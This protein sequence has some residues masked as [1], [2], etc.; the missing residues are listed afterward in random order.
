[1]SEGN[2]SRFSLFAPADF[3]YYVKELE[4]FLSEESYVKYKCEVEVALAK[5]LAK[6]G[7]I[8]EDSAKE[9]ALASKR[10]TAEE[11][12]NEEQRTQHDIIALINMIRTKISDEAKSAV[13][14]TATSYDIV[15]TAN[16]KRYRDAF[17]KIIIP[18]LV[19]LEKVLIDIA[20]REKE[21]V[22]I[23][24]THLQHAEPITFGFAISWYVSRFG[25][26]LMKIYRS[27][28]EMEGKFSGAVGAYNASFLFVDDPEDFEKEVLSELGLKPAEIST[29][30]IQ[31]ENLTD[32]M[33]Y[34]VSTSTIM[35]NLADDLRNL[36]RPEIGEV[37]QPRGED[38][39]RSS[40][41]PHKANPVGLE[42][43]ESLWKVV[44]PFM[45]TMYLDQISNHQR[46]LTNSASQRNIPQVLDLFDYSVRRMTR[47]LRNLRPHT[48]N[49]LRNFEMNKDKIVAEPLQLLLSSYGHPN[50]HEYVSKL[51]D[52]SY[53]TGRS[54]TE[55]VQS[56]PALSLYLKKFTSRQSAILVNPNTYLGIASRK[57]EEITN[58]WEQ[59]LKEARLIP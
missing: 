48:H 30:I 8:S 16:S 18:D 34:V 2:L 24:R 11:V 14:R 31:P 17:L 25:K 59:K 43:V 9:I 29:Q 40:T 15:D 53:E 37:G 46:D 6:R 7:I 3:R 35:S 21:T 42:N 36:Q 50:A 1:M 51:V 55:I 10:V 32:L 47:I 5:V 38:I 19:S 52:K 13:H 45:I 44:M 26:S 56:D 54:L 22:Q 39:S 49:M 41:M 23:G 57:T 27:I 12:Y 20:R 4:P 58:V 28:N 33:H